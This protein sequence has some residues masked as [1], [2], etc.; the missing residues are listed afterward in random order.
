MKLVLRAIA[1]GSSVTYEQLTGDLS[2]VNFSSIRAGLIEARREIE[3]WQAQTFVH[4]FCR[5]VR[6]RWTV[7]AVLAGALDIQPGAYRR[8]PRA[9]L[10]TKWMADGWDWV[11]PEKQ[12][13]ADILEIRSG[14]NSRTRAAAARGIPIDELNREL[15][16]EQ[17]EAD[18]LGLVFE[19]DG[20]RKMSSF[21]RGS[22]GPGRESGGTGDAPADDAG[23]EEGEEP[24]DGE[25]EEER[26]RA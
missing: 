20:R 8:N 9:F 7:E 11:D 15:A 23:G 5:G 22:G 19:T 4:Q 13:R 17:A 16:A 26:R 1:V 18:A 21:G 3:Q 2:G 14:L 12:S 24:A 6:R 10:R 25:Q